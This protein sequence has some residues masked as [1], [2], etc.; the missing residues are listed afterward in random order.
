M[1]FPASLCTLFCLF[2]VSAAH[3]Q[4]APAPQPAPLTAQSIQ[5]RLSA[6]FV[7]LRGMYSGDALHFDDQGIVIGSPDTQPFALSALQIENVRLKTTELDIK[8]KRLGLTFLPPDKTTHTTAIKPVRLRRT[9]P[10]YIVIERDPTHPEALSAALNK[11]FAVRFDKQLAASAPAYWQPWLRHQM[12]PTVP[13]FK[14]AEVSIAKSLA[15][16]AKLG[17]TAPKLLHSVDPHFS[18]A[19]RRLRFH[20]TSI[21]ELIVDTSGAP[22]DIFIRQPVGM[23]L[24]QKAVEA[25]RQYRFSPAMKDGKPI[26]LFVAIAVS[27]R[28]R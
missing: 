19:A 2:T 1:K 3:A 28:I 8:A 21:I 17:I 6:P 11:I 27:F 4:S 5:A 25:I 7:I 15:N 22:R 23:G 16:M 10:L 24:D 18:N 26:P 12:D 14:P 9:D 20:G 13:F